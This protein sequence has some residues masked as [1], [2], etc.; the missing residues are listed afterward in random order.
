M[1]IIEKL[2]KPLDVKLSI[3][4]NYGQE[5][6]NKDSKFKIGDHVR[7]RKY[8]NIS[9]NGYVSDWS[10]EIFTIKNVKNTTIDICY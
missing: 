5:I 3:Y 7:N 6:N 8:K 1:H 10:E 2:M 4:V 9:A